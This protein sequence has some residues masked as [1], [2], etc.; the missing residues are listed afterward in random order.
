MN[1]YLIDHTPKF[2]L[3]M[4]RL[5][6][7]VLTGTEYTLHIKNRPPNSIMT[8]AIVFL[9]ALDG[10]RAEVVS[11]LKDKNADDKWSLIHYTRGGGAAIRP[12]DA[13][14]KIFRHVLHVD[15][16]KRI[17]AA[18]VKGLIDTTQAGA[19]DFANVREEFPEALIAAYLMEKAGMSV[20]KCP[21]LMEEAA[22]V[23]GGQ[24]YTVALDAYFKR[25]EVR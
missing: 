9:H 1:L 24:S 4:A 20:D 3:D 25:Q 21:G 2:C 14:P 5:D 12:D 22:K 7:P 17:S 19:P 23:T 16:V 10:D 15:D 18:W 13:H 8:P 11:S 6:F